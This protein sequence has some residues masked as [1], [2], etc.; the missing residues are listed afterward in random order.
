MNFLE[1]LGKTV[2]TAVQTVEHKSSSAAQ[3]NRIR[4]YIRSQEKAEEQQ[5]LA[6]GRYYYHTLRDGSN[7]VTE[8]HCTELDSIEANLKSAREQ[9]DFFYSCEHP[10]S[11][12]IGVIHGEDGP[13]AVFISHKNDAEREEVTLD[14]VQCF[15]TDPTADPAP[16]DPN[17]NDDL[18]FE[19]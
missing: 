3:L 4:A 6:L 10:E 11:A 19:G 1:K 15:D 13:T 12:S 7:A 8:G 5:F 18:P 9:L 16:A 17:E 14:D 2:K